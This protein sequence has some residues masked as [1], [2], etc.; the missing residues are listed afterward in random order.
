MASE[1]LKDML[2]DG[3]FTAR[4]SLCDATSAFS[5]VARNHSFIAQA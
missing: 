1:L 4:C 3:F 5:F 2:R